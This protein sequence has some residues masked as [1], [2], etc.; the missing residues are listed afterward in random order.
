M[1][2]ILSFIVFLILS[3]SL[4]AQQKL[5]TWKTQPLSQT[6][7]FLI[8][9]H[10]FDLLLHHNDTP[11]SVSNSNFDFVWT[12]GIARNISK[13]VALGVVFEGATE[14]LD[15]PFSIKGRI[16]FWPNRFI[17][18]DFGYGRT[19]AAIHTNDY[20]VNMGPNHSPILN[21]QLVDSGTSID[22]GISLNNLVGLY[23]RRV[24]LPYRSVEFPYASL[25]PIVKK[26]DIRGL[27]GGVRFHHKLGLATGLIIPISYLVHALVEARQ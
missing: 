19:I 22:F 3:N 17:C 9:E 24:S 21:A 11:G 1:R 25:E 7:F 6:K 2:T 5:L 15:F 16:K 27:H 10:S 26:H 4:S 20:C 18:L 13:D 23:L 14:R 12:L 8:T